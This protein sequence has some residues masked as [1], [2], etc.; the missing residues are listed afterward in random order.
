MIVSGVRPSISL[1]SFPTAKTFLSTFEIATTDGSFIIIPR[2]GTYTKTVVVPKSIP[3]FL[4][5][6]ALKENRGASRWLTSSDFDGI[7]KQSLTLKLNDK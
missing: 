5:N 6:I 4:S 1:A 3:I 2:F 7:F